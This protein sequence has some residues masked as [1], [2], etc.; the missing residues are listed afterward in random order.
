LEAVV[1]APPQ[2]QAHFDGAMKVA[3]DHFQSLQ[4]CLGG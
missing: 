2:R 3:E 4:V 1:H